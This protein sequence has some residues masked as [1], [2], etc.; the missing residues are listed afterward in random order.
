MYLHNEK[1]VTA[2]ANTR[3][4]ARLRTSLVVTPSSIR[5]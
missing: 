3:I 2:P 5:G 1:Y 4:V